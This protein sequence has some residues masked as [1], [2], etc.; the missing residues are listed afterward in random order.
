MA[1]TE[2]RIE[3]WR[4]FDEKVLSEHA[5]LTSPLKRTYIYRGQSDAG[6]ALIP[7][8]TRLAIS[9]GFDRSK[10]LEVEQG[11]RQ[12]FQA[13]AH[14]FLDAKVLPTGFGTLLVT[15]ASLQWWTLMQ[16]YGA[17]T[18][19]LD[20]THSPQVALYFAV[21]DRWDE[22]GA[23]WTLQRGRFMAAARDR[24]GAEPGDESDQWRAEDPPSRV[25]SFDP[26]RPTPRMTA[27]QGALTVSQDLL[28]DHAVGIEDVVDEVTTDRERFVLRRKYVIPSEVKPT[29][30]RQLHHMNV[31]AAVLFPGIDGLGAE[32]GEMVRLG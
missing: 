19:L 1:W 20:W 11:L 23:V 25:L 29:L 31:T 16:H 21:R 7:S 8:L 10:A 5:A 3:S 26:Q 27:Q 18:R 6:W 28:L 15:D 4:D 32:L 14:Q 12:R 24:F 17:P 22:D 30:L 2:Y 9:L 13:R